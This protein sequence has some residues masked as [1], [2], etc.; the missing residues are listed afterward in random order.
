MLHRN[1]SSMVTYLFFCSGNGGYSNHF[2]YWNVEIMGGVERGVNL[3][4]RV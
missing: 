1:K 4:N 3:F 2:K